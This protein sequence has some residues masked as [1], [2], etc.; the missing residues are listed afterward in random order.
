MGAGVEDNR[1]SEVEHPDKWA[2]RNLDELDR[3]YA[4]A[5]REMSTGAGGA[6]DWPPHLLIG[7]KI[8]YRQS[9]VEAW[10]RRREASC[11]GSAEAMS[12]EAVSWGT[13]R[14]EH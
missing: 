10:V 3:A 7:K 4:T 2:H 14:R 12:A 8:Y 5:V 1:H 11:Q 13:S 6:A 9:Q